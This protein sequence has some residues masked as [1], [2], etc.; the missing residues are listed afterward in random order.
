MPPVGNKS[1]AGNRKLQFQSSFPL[2]RGS[3]SKEKMQRLPPEIADVLDMSPPES[4]IVTRGVFDRTGVNQLKSLKE[5][6]KS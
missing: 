4:K 6:T 3:H 2:S 5:M 1:I